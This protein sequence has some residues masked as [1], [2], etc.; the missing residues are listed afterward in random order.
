ML[1][2]ALVF[3]GTAVAEE[4]LLQK[5][6][7]TCHNISGPVAQTLKEAL[8]KKGPDLS[9]AG[10]KYLQKWIVSW[11]QK[12]TRIRPAG[13]YYGDHIKPGPKGDE[14]DVSTLTDHVAISKEDATAIAAELMKLKPH[15]DLIAKEKIVPGTITKQM[16]EMN[17]DKFQGCMTCHLIEPE[18]GGFSGPQVY[19]AANRL[20]PEFMA[21]FIR[22]PQAWEPKTWMPNKHVSDSGIQ[23]LVQYLEMLSKEAVNAK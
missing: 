18:Y 5:D 12:P 9:Y 13:M 21:S 23:K 14:I 16:G 19:T 2:A 22:N 3:S 20:Q 1:S 15:D 17:F 6:C 7:A 4:G 8:A 11:L 10:N